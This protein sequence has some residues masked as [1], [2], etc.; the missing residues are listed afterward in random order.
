MNRQQFRQVSQEFVTWAGKFRCGVDGHLECVNPGALTELVIDL[1]IPKSAKVPERICQK[2][3]FFRLTE[4][5]RWRATGMTEGS[6]A[7]TRAKLEALSNQITK[8]TTDAAALAACESILRWGGDRNSTVGALP[9]LQS[10]PSVLSYLNAVKAELALKTAVVPPTGSLQAVVAMNSMLTKVHSLNS[11]DGLP[12]YD[13]RVAGAIATLVETWRL[14]LVPLDKPL[15]KALSFPEVGAG[16][17]RRS[18]H[19]RYPESVKPP[20]LYY[21]TGSQSAE[22]AM[23]IAKEWASAKVRLGW[24]LSELLAEPTPSGLRSLEACLF[25]AGYDCARINR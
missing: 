12:I 9:F 19:A 7:E 13:S 16:G 25:M 24:L 3:P 18:V 4:V 15:P 8:A 14:T 6:F 2:V 21:A 10:Q 23:V 1:N 5:Y 22:R 11:G 17:Q 20:T